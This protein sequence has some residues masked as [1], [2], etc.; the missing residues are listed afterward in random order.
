MGTRKLSDG[1]SVKVTAPA[2]GVTANTF[3]RIDGFM[4]HVF[5]DA[6]AGDECIL[7]VS[8]C[9]VETDQALSTDTFAVGEA[10]YWDDTAKKFTTTVGSNYLYGKATEAKASGTGVAWIKRTTL[11]S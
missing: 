2:G 10:I 5:Q 11:D 6:D 3:Y 7:D 1:Q 9:E 8:L 4:G